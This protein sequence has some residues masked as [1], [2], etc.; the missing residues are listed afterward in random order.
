MIYTKPVILNEIKKM[1]I[2]FCQFGYA[3]LGTEWHGSPHIIGHDYFYMIMEGEA[4]LWCN[5]RHIHMTPGNIYVIPNG[6]IRTVIN[7]TRDYRC[8]LVNI[9]I[10]HGQDIPHILSALQE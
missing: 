7:M 9:T 2:D 4:D 8:A 5:G 10:A 6:D 1:H 3:D